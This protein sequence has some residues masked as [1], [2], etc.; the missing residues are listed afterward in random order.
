MRMN[1][2][3]LWFLSFVIQSVSFSVE[4]QNSKGISFR[5]RTLQ[6]RIASLN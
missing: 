6:S 3:L 1:F 2:V 4:N 5:G